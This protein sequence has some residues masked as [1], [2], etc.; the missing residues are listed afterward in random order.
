MKKHH[1]VAFAYNSGRGEWLLLDD[2][3]AIPVRKKEACRFVLR[4]ASLGGRL[5]ARNVALLDVR[6]LRLSGLRHFG[7][8][9]RPGVDGGDANVGMFRCCRPPGRKE[10]VF[11]I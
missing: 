3:K 5:L 8:S 9:R 4:G 10:E 6:F 11:I 7:V 1:Y 2:D